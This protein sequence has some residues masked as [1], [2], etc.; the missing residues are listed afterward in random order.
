[1][2]IYNIHTHIYIYVHM[3]VYVCVFQNTNYPE[4]CDWRILSLKEGWVTKIQKSG[5]LTKTFRT[6]ILP[7][8]ILHISFYLH[9]I[10]SKG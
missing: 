8:S 2:Y 6:F 10:L 9:I 4:S 7:N 5:Q 3:C 1:M